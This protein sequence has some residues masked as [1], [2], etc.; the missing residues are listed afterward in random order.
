[1]SD[2]AAILKQHLGDPE[3]EWSLGTFGAIAEFHRDADERATL[4]EWEGGRCLITARAAISIA[5]HPQAT[6]LP[7]ETLSKIPTAWS[8]GVMV[9]LPKP[10]AAFSNRPGLTDL[11]GDALALLPTEPGARLFDLGLGLGHIDVCIRTSDGPLTERLSGLAGRAFLD[12]PGDAIAAIKTANPVRVFISRLARIEVDQP[13]PD[14]DGVTPPG[15][16]THLL[17]KLLGRDR[18]HAANLPIPDDQL[19]CLAFYP[20]HPLRDPGGDLKAFEHEPFRQFQALVE[21]HAPAEIVAAKRLAWQALTAGRPPSK[22]DLPRSRAAR[23]A[24]RVALR[25]AGHTLGDSPALNA[26]RDLM[27]PNQS[28]TTGLMEPNQSVTTGRP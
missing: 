28:V 22:S 10:T 24:L 25:Q 11:G 14:S 1:M 26:W 8:Q 20:R 18:S 27:E 7:Y 4:E 13:I 12:L 21:D 19:A 9:C 2:I 5:D 3:T 16:H 23:T 17:P 6:L 15:P